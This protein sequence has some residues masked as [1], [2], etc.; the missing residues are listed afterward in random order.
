MG[1]WDRVKGAVGGAVGGFASGG[2]WGALAGGAY[3]ALASGGG[4]GGGGGFGGLLPGSGGFELQNDAANNQMNLANS[5]TRMGEEQYGQESP[6]R[7]NMLTA[8]Q[9]RANE[10]QQA[11]TPTAPTMYNPFNNTYRVA[12]THGPQGV[13][14]G[15]EG[16]SGAPAYQQAQAPQERGMGG[17]QD[18]QEIPRVGQDLQDT[19]ERVA[20]EP[21]ATPHQPPPEAYHQQ[22]RINARDGGANVISHED[23]LVEDQ[24]ADPVLRHGGDGRDGRAYGPNEYRRGYQGGDAAGWKD[25]QGSTS[26]TG[27]YAYNEDRLSPNTENYYS[28]KDFDD[29]DDILALR[30]AELEGWEGDMGPMEKPIVEERSAELKAQDDVDW[31]ASVRAKYSTHDY[32]LYPDGPDG[33]NGYVPK[34]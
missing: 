2:P 34:Q 14:R 26:Y 5:L 13:P 7:S 30:Q 12:P 33:P 16:F 17:G 15:H 27:N 23:M 18:L 29:P 24:T 28:A 32:D 10:E 8:I 22:D 3:G 1:G 21:P 25:F 6:Y 20:S 11:Y 9:N 19:R 31:E 4:G